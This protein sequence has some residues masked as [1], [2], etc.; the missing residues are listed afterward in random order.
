MHRIRLSVYLVKPFPNM[1][2]KIFIHFAGLLYMTISSQNIQS[3]FLIQK[4][5]MQM[6]STIIFTLLTVHL[7]LNLV[8]G[9]QV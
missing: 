5:P 6:E 8:S 7:L 9:S 3:T 2:I 1:A 4:V